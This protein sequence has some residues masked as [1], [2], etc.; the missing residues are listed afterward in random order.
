MK[1]L[2]LVVLHS[3]FTLPGV[4]AAPFQ[5]HIAVIYGVKLYP[6]VHWYM[7]GDGTT[8]AHGGRIDRPAMALIVIAGLFVVVAA[9]IVFSLVGFNPTDSVGGTKG[10]TSPPLEHHDDA[11]VASALTAS[12]VRIA[13]TWRDNNPRLAVIAQALSATLMTAGCLPMNGCRG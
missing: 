9:V 11:E 12:A 13:A 10:T 1:L 5:V 7:H 8:Y 4:E 2:H 6:T 3:V